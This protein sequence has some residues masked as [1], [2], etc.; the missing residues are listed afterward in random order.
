MRI[1]PDGE[2]IRE[3]YARFG[4][5][6]YESECLHRKLCFVHGIDGNGVHQ[7]L[8]RSAAILLSCN[9]DKVVFV[10]KCVRL[11]SSAA[12]LVLVSHCQRSLGHLLHIISKRAGYDTCGSATSEAAY[13][14]C[15]G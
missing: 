12:H 6:Y 3:L 7:E 15:R 11:R 14:R 4:L 9:L 5:A 1:E 2:L 13:E 8:G 10:R